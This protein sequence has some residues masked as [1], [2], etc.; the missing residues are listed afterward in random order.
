[1]Q[2][3]AITLQHTLQLQSHAAAAPLAPGASRDAGGAFRGFLG[4]GSGNAPAVGAAGAAAAA[5][6]AG[7]EEAILSGKEVLRRLND[8]GD[9]LREQQVLYES[10]RYAG[11]L[12]ASLAATL[13]GCVDYDMSSKADKL[14]Q[15][16]G[17]SERTLHWARLLGLLQRGQRLGN[18][19]EVEK[20]LDGWFGKNSKTQVSPHA[21]A[22]A[23]IEA[24]QARAA[25]P[26]IQRL[27]SIVERLELWVTADRW[28]DAAMD[29]R[30]SGDADGSKQA[31]LRRRAG[32][33]RA[34][35]AAIDQVFGGGR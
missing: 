29:I 33:N 18:W 28:G 1:V 11:F 30:K 8:Q 21:V 6:Q 2:G 4:G 12:N 35:L 13:R 9:L 32:A 24:N 10:T 14:A 34:A 20:Q 25:G 26:Y 3:A 22:T 16:F 5:G 17:A 19:L 27:P 15:K 23:L 31:Q 7:T